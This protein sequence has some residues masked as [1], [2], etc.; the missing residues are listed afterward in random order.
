MKLYT[1][2]VGFDEL[3]E[4]LSNSFILQDSV[5]ATAGMEV[6]KTYILFPYRLEEQIG[7]CF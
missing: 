6:L 1:S 4:K 7:N 5:T 2:A 3:S